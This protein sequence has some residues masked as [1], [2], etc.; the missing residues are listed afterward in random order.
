MGV[1]V[2]HDQQLIGSP[3]CRLL[4]TGKNSGTIFQLIQYA[5]KGNEIQAANGNYEDES[6]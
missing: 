3:L 4:A 6:P 5:H 2:Q 1:G